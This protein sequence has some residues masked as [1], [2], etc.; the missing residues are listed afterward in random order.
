MEN[1]RQNKRLAHLVNVAQ[2]AVIESQGNS[3]PGK[4]QQAQNA[5]QETKLF[6]QESFHPTNAEEDA[7]LLHAKELIRNLEE[8]QHAIEATD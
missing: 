6:L 3:D 4:Y 8:A 2:A 7:Q 1:K 5:I